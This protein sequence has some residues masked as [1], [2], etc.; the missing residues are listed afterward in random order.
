MDSVSKLSI[1]WK[2][3]LMGN[4]KLPPTVSD[5]RKLKRS[6]RIAVYAIYL[7][8]CSHLVHPPSRYLETDRR[9]LS[10]E[11]RINPAET[12]RRQYWSVGQRFLVSMWPAIDFLPLMRSL[13]SALVMQIS[14]KEKYSNVPSRLGIMP[15]SKKKKK[16]FH[17]MLFN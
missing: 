9:V 10:H 7:R 3:D 17:S 13:R 6:D 1:N 11:P 8:R 15:N 5:I 2:Y 16:L 4:M 12:N 14:S